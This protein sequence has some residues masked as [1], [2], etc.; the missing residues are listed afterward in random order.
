M[1]RWKGRTHSL[2]GLAGAAPLPE[3]PR[4]GLA[5]PHLCPLGSLLSLS[6]SSVHLHMVVERRRGRGLVKSPRCCPY[7]EP[8]GNSSTSPDN[9]VVGTCPGTGCSG[10]PAGLF[11]SPRP[12][13]WGRAHHHHFTGKSTEAQ[14]LRAPRSKSPA[15]RRRR[16][17]AHSGAGPQ[18]RLSLPVCQVELVAP[19]LSARW[20]VRG[21]NCAGEKPCLNPDGSPAPQAS[22]VTPRDPSAEKIRARTRWWP[23]G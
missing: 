7:R 11:S 8:A 18:S 9:L 6:G 20:G 10:N 3:G 22:P 17:D 13:R 2:S 12:G 5:L 4:H 15:G 21:L 1:F 23:R 19:T 14:S 16:Q